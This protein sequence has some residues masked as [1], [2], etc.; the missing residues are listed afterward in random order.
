MEEVLLLD[1]VHKTINGREIIKGISF[2]IK[3]GEV[4]GFLGPNGSG[5]STTLRMIVGLSKPTE[6]QIKICGN[7]IVKNYVKAMSNVGCIIEGPDLYNYMTGWD[8]LEMLAVMNKNIS[9]QD[10]I[11]AATIVGMEKH[12]KEKVGTYSLGMK[13][14]MGVAQAIMNK[15][16][17]LILDEPTNGLDPSGI[18]EFRNLINRFA[19]EENMAVLISSHLMS[20]IE[21]ICDNVSIIK[22]GAILK[23]AV[24]KEL[25]NSQEVFW[26]LD[27]NKKAMDILNESWGIN[28]KIDGDKLVAS[29]DKSIISEIN[30]SFIRE[31]LK[32][33]F[34]D[35]RH[36]TLEDLFLNI[37]E[38]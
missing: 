10:I 14:R 2:S 32:L 6:G 36:K 13:Q 9:K 4:L 24:V 34:V 12:L 31:G 26:I 11:S 22:N 25:L 20:E 21:L 1:N 38:N 37:T 29:M 15:P 7:S 3:A 28:S 27:D 16:R 18:N 33:K 23:N 17:L 8:N 19:K 30:A 35:N 5:K